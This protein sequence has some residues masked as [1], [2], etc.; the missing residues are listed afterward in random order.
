MTGLPLPWPPGPSGFHPGLSVLTA[1][2]PWRIV[3][4]GADRRL[5][6]VGGGG[7]A[8]V[9]EGGELRLWGPCSGVVRD[10]GEFYLFLVSAP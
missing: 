7:M 10:G 2:E 8:W 3:T 6:W 9:R 1:L 5:A 4:E